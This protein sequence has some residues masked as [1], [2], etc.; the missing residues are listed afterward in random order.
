[1]KRFFRWAAAGIAAILILCSPAN[2]ARSFHIA[3]QPF[4]T[5]EELFYDTYVDLQFSVKRLGRRYTIKDVKGNVREI[6]SYFHW[7]PVSID[8]E[9]AKVFK[10]Y[11]Q[12]IEKNGKPTFRIMLVE[13]EYYVKGLEIHHHIFM[14]DTNLDAQPDEIT[15]NWVHID[16]S[17]GKRTVTKLVSKADP[18]KGKDRKSL[19]WNK[20]FGY[21]FKVQ[22]LEF[23]ETFS[24]RP[25]P[26]NP[27]DR[28]M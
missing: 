19:L 21:W 1:M 15:E 9:K 22:V 26:T 11:A 16:T 27:K 13:I 20:W 17:K 10:V 24:R 18:N 6:S 4:P 8:K 28:L 3:P 25:F 2:A 14:D 12:S 23:K 7:F 5:A